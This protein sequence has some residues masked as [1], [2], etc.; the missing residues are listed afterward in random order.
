[1]PATT[2]AAADA[3]FDAIRRALA[4]C[5]G[6][7]T[8]LALKRHRFALLPRLLPPHLCAELKQAID[9]LPSRRVSLGNGSPPT[10]DSTDIPP[11]HAISTLFGDS[12]VYR[13]I[14]DG[15]DGT[16]LA[17]NDHICWAHRYRHGEFIPQ[18]VD[19]MG[20]LQML[21][22]VHRSRGVAGGEF[23]IKRG[24]RPFAYDLHCGDAAVFAATQHLHWTTTLAAARSNRRGTRL[25][26]VSR[27]LSRNGNAIAT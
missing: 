23:C 22:V 17:V 25:V 24:R 20:V 15:L 21:I 4:G 27:F 16:A 11:S 6:P 5:F 1:M 14:N 10:W 26:L 13:G 12:A 7:A 8:T 2:A 18:H 3:N 19:S 9:R